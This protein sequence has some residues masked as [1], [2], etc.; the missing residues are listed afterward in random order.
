MHSIRTLHEQLKNREIT[1]VSLVEKAFQAIQARDNDIHAFVYTC[2]SEAMEKAREVDSLFDEGEDLPLIAGIPFSAKDAFNIAGHPTCA[3]SHI[4]EG[5][6]SPY[7]ATSIQRLLDAH[8]IFIGK[9]NQDSF[10]F[11]SSTENSDFGVTHN[12]YDSSKVAGGSSGG[13]AAAV[14][15]GMGVFSMG[16][17][18][19][20]SIRQPAC[21]NGVTGLKVTYGMVSRYGVVAYASSLDTI[22][23]IAR[24]VD[25]VGIVMEYIAGRDPFDATTFDGEFGFVQS[26]NESIEGL[27]FGVPK[28]FVDG[29]SDPEI[30]ANMQEFLSMITDS[31][32]VLVDVSLPLTKYGVSAYYLIAPSEASSNL[33]RYDGMRFGLSDRDGTSVD[34]IFSDTRGKGFNDEV[35]RRVLLGTYAL[36]SGYYDAYFDK[37]LRVRTL[38]KQDLESTLALVDCLIA[39][40]SPI[41]PF[42]PD[43]DFSDDPTAM[44]MIDAFTLLVNVAGVPA[45]SIPSGMS[46]SG[47]PMGVQLIG[48]QKDEAFLLAIGKIFEASSNMPE[49]LDVV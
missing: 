38:M 3:G 6:V 36:S 2:E 12:A 28:E 49:T 9:T 32:G 33:S 46:R 16:E 45:L 5:Y 29:I 4:L 8:A 25:D 43:A 7:T 34:D 23:P 21:F 15:A 44:W 30:Q 1:A 40:V 19:G 47:L 48:K 42:A 14:A 39:P 20:G 27:R 22:G 41:L 37:A 26:T 10:G 31:G 24:S 13:S 11:G 18:T 17:D 35:K